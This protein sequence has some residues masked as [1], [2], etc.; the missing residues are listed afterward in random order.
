M[1]ASSGGGARSERSRLRRVSDEIALDRGEDCVEFFD[2]EAVT[3][4]GYA[5]DLRVREQRDVVA[6]RS[7]EMFSKA[8]PRV[9]KSVR[10]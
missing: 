10:P 8:L 1:H 7:F 5:D 9:C 3:G 2:E 6:A 4:V